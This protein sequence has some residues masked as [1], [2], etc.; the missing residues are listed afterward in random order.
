M[1]L[2]SEIIDKPSIMP[3][4]YAPIAPGDPAPWFRQRSTSNPSYAFDTVAGRYVVM[5]FFGSAADPATQAALDAVRRHRALFDDVR[6][7]FFG[8]SVDPAD[9][10]QGRVQ[11]SLPGIRFFLDFDTAV[12]RLYGAVAS[13]GAGDAETV[14]MRR[15]WLVLDTTLR[16]I[17]VLPFAPDG[18]DRTA[19]FE[20][21]RGLPPPGRAPGGGGEL[22]VPVLWLPDVFEPELCRTLIAAYERHGGA[23]SGFMR[24]VEGKT[25]LVHD[26]SHKRRRDF[27]VEDAD[28][29]RTIQT[30]VARRI[31][32]EIQKVH[33]FDVTR[34]ERYL[35]ACYRAE[36]A[37]HF[38]PHR[39]NTTKGTAHR[40]FAVSINLN[41]GFQGG[42]LSFPEFGPRQFRP[43][44]GGAVVFSCSLMHTVSPVTKG[45]R[46]AFLPFLYDDAAAKLRA[47]NQ[48]FLGPGYEYTP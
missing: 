8:V 3:P 18:S 22:P 14:E 9:A 30:R 25:T 31:K 41:E 39:D 40:R 45:H 16:V 44:V 46:F 29:I 24:D 37:G 38:R 32:P 28:L 42:D 2:A 47:S 26:A 6:A 35:V 1:Q 4:R 21:L 27:T 5:C 20:L 17:A 10:A 23:E 12:S 7:C 48:Q 11:E 43:P 13:D 19:V 33:H 34:M 15:F 36:D